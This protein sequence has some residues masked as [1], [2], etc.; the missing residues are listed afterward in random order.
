MT[1]MLRW[2]LLAL[3]LA[4]AKAR[5]L[6]DACVRLCLAR[7]RSLEVT[8]VCDHQQRL[9]LQSTGGRYP[10]Q[11]LLGL[12][13]IPCNGPGN[14]P[15]LF[16]DSQICRVFRESMIRR[17]GCSC[18]GTWTLETDDAP[19]LDVSFQDSYSRDS[20]DERSSMSEAAALVDVAKDRRSKHKM[21]SLGIE[22]VLLN[23]EEWE[24]SVDVGISNLNAPAKVDSTEDPVD[25]DL[26]C[27]AQC[28][29]GHGGT[30]CNCDLIP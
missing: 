22:D 5:P 2:V 27:M 9:V 25:W 24:S 15:L 11:R 4:G 29:N 28:D 20:V 26:W 12:C 19:R 30:A 21:Q 18:H 7:D 14:D 17:R 10:T 6:E 3:L 8:G 1:P 13:L 23:N 16:D